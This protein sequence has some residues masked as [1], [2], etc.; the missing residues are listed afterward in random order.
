MPAYTRSCGSAA[1]QR[2]EERDSPDAPHD[3]S[4]V[5]RQLAV[6][7]P[8]AGR[9]DG[10][11]CRLPATD[12][13]PGIARDFTAVTLRSW[14]VGALLDDAAVIVSELVTNAIRHGPTAGGRTVCDEQITLTLV[15]HERF[16]VC[17]VSDSGHQG[18]TMREPDDSCENG[19]GLVVIEA[20]SHVWGWTPIPGSGKAIWAALTIG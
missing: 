6:F 16:L 3:L 9:P 12:A 19:R 18:P 5:Q 8:G 13:S 10:E 4:G 20:L 11:V 7:G 17:V 1:D 15:R 2:L 14:G